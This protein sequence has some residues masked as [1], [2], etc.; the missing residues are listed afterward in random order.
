[1]RERALDDASELCFWGGCDR[2][3]GGDGSSGGFDRGKRVVMRVRLVGVVGVHLV[4]V[5]VMREM[6]RGRVGG[7]M[8]K[9]VVVFV[10][11]R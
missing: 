8:R 2:G 11:R 5:R 1:M 10:G 3:I 9:G 4:V 6:L 7:R